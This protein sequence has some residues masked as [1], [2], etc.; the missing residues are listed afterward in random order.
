ML[1]DDVEES[2]ESEDICAA[3]ARLSA[4]EG[5]SPAAEGGSEDWSPDDTLVGPLF[6]DATL[7]IALLSS[8]R[9]IQAEV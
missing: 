1:T 5:S 2:A 3:D 4:G 8:A 9:E 6:D 7:M